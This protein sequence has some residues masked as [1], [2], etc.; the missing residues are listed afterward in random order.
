ML[1]GCAE[2][3]RYYKVRNYKPR[4]STM[5]FSIEPPPGKGWYETHKNKSLIYLKKTNPYKYSFQTKATEINFSKSIQLKD[6]FIKYVH[7]KKIHSL[8]GVNYKNAK[9]DYSIEK[10]D[11]ALC[12]KYKYI[13]E[14]HGYKN[15]KK[16]EYVIIKNNGLVCIHPDIPTNGIELSYLEKTISSSIQQSYIKEGEKFLNGL[17]F[18]SRKN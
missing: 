11:A 7:N 13:Y 17:A 2:K 4:V 1:A 5:G 8:Q 16:N 15:L 12:V 18:V 6:D 10:K 14:D 9:L 3:K